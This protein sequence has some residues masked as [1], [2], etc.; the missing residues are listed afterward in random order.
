MDSETAAR[1]IHSA[2]ERVPVARPR[3]RRALAAPRGADRLRLSMLELHDADGRVRGARGVPRRASCARASSPTSTSATAS[4]QP[5]RREPAPRRR[6]RARCRSSPRGPRREPSRHSAARH[7]RVGEWEPT[8]APD[9]YAAAVDEVRAAIARGDVYQVNL[10]QHLSAPFDG[11]PRR[12][13]RR[14]RAAAAAAPAAA[15]RRR[16]GDRLGLARA[17]PRAARRPARDDA[18]QGHAARSARTSTTPKDAAEHVM[19]VDLERNDLSRVCEPGSIRWPEL[20]A[21]HELAGVTHLVSTVEGRAARRT[22]ALA[23]ILARDVP[24]RLDHRRAED[25]GDRPHRARSSR[26]AAARRWARSGRSAPNGDFELALTIRTFAVADG[27]VHLWV[28]GGIVWDSDPEAEIE[29]SWVKARPLLAAVGGL[30]AA[31]DAARGRRRRA[32]ARRSGRA[33]LRAPTT[34]RCCAAAPAFETLRVY[35]GRPFLLDRAPRAARRT[36]RDALGLPPADGAEELAALRRRRGAA[37]SRPAA[38]PH[39]ATTLVATAAALPAGPRGAAR[40]RPRA[41]DGRVGAPRRCSPVSKSTS[42]APRSRRAARPSARA[43]TTRSSSPTGSC[44]RRR[45]RT[46]GGARGDVLYTPAPGP[47]CCPG[48]TRAVLLELAARRSRRARSARASSPRPTRRS[49][50]PRSAR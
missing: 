46:S 4:R 10:V 37:R 2:N 14:A 24:G 48:V 43:P 23:E 8:W 5:L 16:L 26:S 22:S 44:S 18:D 15:R 50:P 29:E 25:R 31:H 38:L 6:S 11:D 35:G 42:Y 45:P 3:A 36:R 39:E 47:A 41:A 33:G 49:P 21:Q 1:L 7:F 34:R 30:G 28:G 12:A 17:L 19:I 9:D 40:A 32:R 20:M 27:R 13:R